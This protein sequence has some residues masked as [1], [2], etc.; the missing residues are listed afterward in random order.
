MLWM[1]AG[2]GTL[3]VALLVATAPAGNRGD[4]TAKAKLSG[5]EEV[6]PVSTTGDGRFK[7]TIRDSSIEYKLEYSDL[8]GTAQAAHIH[9]GQERVNGGIIAFLCGGE[10]TP[11]C[12][13]SGTVTGTIT[14]D[15]IIGPASQGIEPREFDEALRAI[16]SG[17][18]YANVHTAPDFSGGEIRGQ[19]DGDDDGDD[20]D[21]NNGKNGRGNDE[22]DDD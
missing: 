14:A 4:D 21:D 15:D 8:D 6:P 17:N 12:P 16:R 7:A 22:R 11:A 1:S 13:P 9:F 18:T 20:D 2:L 19:I 5:F 3:L 10:G